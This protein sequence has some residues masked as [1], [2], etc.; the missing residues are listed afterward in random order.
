MS[1]FYRQLAGANAMPSTTDNPDTALFTSAPLGDNADPKPV[2]FVQQPLADDFAADLTKPWWQSKTILAAV[3]AALPAV[4]H[5]LGFDW[6]LIAPY[7]GD[8]V[9]CVA[10]AGAVYA[11]VTATHALK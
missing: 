3:A 5:L 1:D 7:S 4:A 9:T 8:I 10:A 11:R 6:A 2:L